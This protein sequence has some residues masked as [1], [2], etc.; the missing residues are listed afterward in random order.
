MLSGSARVVGDTCC[1]SF[2]IPNTPPGEDCVSWHSVG[3][4]KFEQHKGSGPD[5]SVPLLLQGLVGPK[6]AGRECAAAA[7]G[8]SFMEAVARVRQGP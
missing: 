8:D 1:P 7:L 6:A 4:W 2:P 3:A 5:T